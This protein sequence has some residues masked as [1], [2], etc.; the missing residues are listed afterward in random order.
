MH[1][2]SG[3]RWH[4]L[5]EPEL[6]LDD[7]RELDRLRRD[8]HDVQPHRRGYTVQFSTETIRAT[9]LFRTLPHEVGHNVDHSRFWDWADYAMDHEG[10]DYDYIWQ[11]Y[12]ARPS[13]EREAF[14]HRYADEF[15]QAMIDAGKF[16]F[17]QIRDEDRMRRDGLDPDWFPII[18]T[19][20]D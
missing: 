1:F 20:R 14:A 2:A 12:D 13:S 6:G 5:T 3:Q 17:P 10:A 11:L 8:G 16:P 18:D 7:Q 4:S 19:H 9:Q 15:R